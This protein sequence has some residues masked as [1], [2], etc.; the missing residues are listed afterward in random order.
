M[1]VNRKKN[2]KDSYTFDNQ[3]LEK[4]NGK[5][6]IHLA[7]M[8]KD[9]GHKK[10]IPAYMEANVELTKKVFNAFLKDETA[11]TFIFVSSVKAAA[12]KIDT[13]L[14]E[15]DDFL[16]EEP[17]GL[18]KKLAETYLLSEELPKNKKLI[19]LR[20]AMIYGYNFKSN[21][22]SLF[23]FVKK[24][25]PYPFSAFNNLRTMLS[26][27]NFTYVIK[28]IINKED[29]KPGIYNVAD[30]DAFSTGDIIKLMAASQRKKARLWPINKRVIKQLGI[31]GDHLHLPINTNKINKLTKNYIISNTKLKKELGT[32]L[33]YSTRD[34]LVKLFESFK[35]NIKEV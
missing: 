13:I 15:E 17:Y 33:P 4:C 20:P 23:A 6:W 31:I 26:I 28:S 24:G 30:D 27:D 14:T 18:S 1:E 25:L 8:S 19:I 32:N 3:D 9:I 5:I 29:F 7:G 12:S 21:L 2:T 10:M 11:S 35:M 22:Y 34:E 16:V